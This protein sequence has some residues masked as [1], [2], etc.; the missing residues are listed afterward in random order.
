MVGGLGRGFAV[1]SPHRC[2][3]LNSGAGACHSGFLL[4]RFRVLRAVVRHEAPAAG[5]GGHQ[6]LDGVL[7]LRGA[8]HDSGNSGDEH[9]DRGQ[10]E[11][12]HRLLQ[13]DLSGLQLDD[14]RLPRPCPV[15]FSSM[16]DEVPEKGQR[17]AAEL[18]RLRPVLLAGVRVPAHDRVRLAQVLPDVA[19]RRPS[20]DYKRPGI[21]KQG[22]APRVERLDHFLP[23]Y[24]AGQQ[25]LGFRGPWHA[26]SH[27]CLAGHRPMAACGNHQLL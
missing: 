12:L 7:V 3:L 19:H 20:P 9:H 23:V 13:R 26:V 2:T 4:D 22:R 27:R 14:L 15:P 24:G 16:L 6:E 10:R 25:D 5:R 8:V 17:Q 1:P 18:G 11:W 21:N